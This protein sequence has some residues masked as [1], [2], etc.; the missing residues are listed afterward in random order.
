MGQAAHHPH[1]S[2]DLQLMKKHLAATADLT[3]AL[4][5]GKLSKPLLELPPPQTGALA[6]SWLPATFF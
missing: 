6:S 1:D 3:R 5:A 2:Q 4:H